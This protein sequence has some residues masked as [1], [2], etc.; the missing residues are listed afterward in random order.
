MQQLTDARND[1]AEAKQ[2]QVEAERNSQML[3]SE[4]FMQ[5]V[6]QRGSNNG[7]N[8]N[9]NNDNNMFSLSGSPVKQPTNAPDF[10]NRD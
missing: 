3:R 9:A 6:A 8:A 7:A 4:E 1:A 2:A 5:F 10:L